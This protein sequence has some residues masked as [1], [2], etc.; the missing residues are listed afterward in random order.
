[1]LK[2]SIETGDIQKY[3]FS[4]LRNILEK[5]STFLGFKRWEE[6]IPGDGE[7]RAAYVKRI[8]NY[9]SHSKQ[10]GEE[11]SFVSSDDKNMLKYL[12]NKISADYNFKSTPIPPLEENP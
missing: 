4:F 2:K 12:V 5:T 3:H 1:V 6:L 8:L 9:S 10:S 7:V 11:V